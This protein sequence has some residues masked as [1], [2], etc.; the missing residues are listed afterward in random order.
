VESRINRSE[1]SALKY[2]VFKIR[3]PGNKSNN[4]LQEPD[5]PNQDPENEDAMSQGPD[6][7]QDQLNL[8][9]NAHPLIQEVFGPKDD[10]GKNG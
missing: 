2:L 3:H 8:M 9:K 7:E 10:S 5:A 6:D 1:L 4:N